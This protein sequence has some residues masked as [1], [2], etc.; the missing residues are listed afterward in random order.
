V[1]GEVWRIY[2]QHDNYDE[3]PYKIVSRTLFRLDMLDCIGKTVFHTKE[4]AEKALA[5]MEK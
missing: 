5:E 2:T 1:G 4:E 3:S